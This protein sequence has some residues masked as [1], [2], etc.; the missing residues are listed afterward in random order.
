MIPLCDVGKP[1][2]VLAWKRVYCMGKACS[3]GETDD[4]GCP[5]AH[6]MPG[7]WVYGNKD[8]TQSNEKTFGGRALSSNMDSHGHTCHHHC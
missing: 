2:K 8:F 7:Y 5:F 4:T 1:D 6:F 3:A